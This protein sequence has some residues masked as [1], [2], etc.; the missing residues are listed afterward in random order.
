MLAV[1]LLCLPLP[2]HLS[3]L[4][5]SLILG[6]HSYELVTDS[7]TYSLTYSMIY[8]I[9]YSM[10]YSITYSVTSMTGQPAGTQPCC[11]NI[12]SNPE[13]Y[14]NTVKPTSSSSALLALPWGTA[15]ACPASAL[16]ARS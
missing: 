6:V 1:V 15:E 9:T 7:M 13:P 10:T 2:A 16:Q 11:M 4:S 5:S 8:S 3:S 12:F 14:R